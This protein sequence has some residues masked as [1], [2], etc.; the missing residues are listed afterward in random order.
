MHRVLGL[1][2]S[3]IVLGLTQIPVRATP[4]AEQIDTIERRLDSV[5]A[6]RIAGLQPGHALREGSPRGLAT[7]PADAPSDAAVIPTPERIAEGRALIR[8][9]VNEDRR[10]DQRACENTMTDAKGLIGALP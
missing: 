6:V 2:A 5:G 3:A 4:C 8:R 7:A 9:A 1:L 10:G